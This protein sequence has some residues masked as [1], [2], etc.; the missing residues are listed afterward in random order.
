MNM[1]ARIKIKNFFIF[2]RVYSTSMPEQQA[3]VQAC[4]IILN[5][6]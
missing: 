6:F 2:V 4:I 5:Y 1:D 3:I